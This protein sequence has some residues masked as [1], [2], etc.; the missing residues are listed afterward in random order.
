[1]GELP[2]GLKAI[3]SDQ[4]KSPE[5]EAIL[6]GLREFNSIYAGKRQR[7]PLTIAIKDAQGD[8]VAGLNS[9][10]H[11]D[12]LFVDHLWVSE[13]HRKTGLGQ[14]LLVMAEKEAQKRGCIAVHL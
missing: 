12:W 6:N 4:E 14:K 5:Y 8:V 1:M 10:T 7:M 9:T 2:A 11:W 3:F 13:T